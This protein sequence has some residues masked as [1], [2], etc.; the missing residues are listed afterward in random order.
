MLQPGD[1]VTVPFQGVTGTKQHPAVVLSSSSYH[2][3][4]PDAILGL[5]TTQI[6]DATTPT[7]YVLQD[8]AEAGLHRASAFRAF[9]VTV[10]TFW[11]HRTSL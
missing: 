1:V 2:S 3:N 4:R 6:A 5:L 9:F 7:D 10:P 11:P 8:W